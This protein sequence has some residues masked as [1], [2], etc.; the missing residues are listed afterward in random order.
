MM[1]AIQLLTGREQFLKAAAPVRWIIAG[2]Q[3]SSLGVVDDGSNAHPSTVGC[4]GLLCPDR[5]KRLNHVIACN[6]GHGLL[7]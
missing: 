5:L 7:V 1:T 4:L 6:V 2:K 3:S